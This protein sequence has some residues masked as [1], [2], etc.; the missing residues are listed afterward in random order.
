MH[1]F[2]AIPEA[3]NRALAFAAGLPY[4]SSDKQNNLKL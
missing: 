3:N 1:L 2:E 4:S